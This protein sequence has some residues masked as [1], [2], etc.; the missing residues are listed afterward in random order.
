MI[1]IKQDDTDCRYKRHVKEC[2][3][4]HAQMMDSPG[5]NEFN[6]EGNGHAQM[7]ADQVKS[8]MLSEQVRR[9]IP[10][11]DFQSAIAKA[12]QKSLFVRKVWFQLSHYVVYTYHKCVILSC[13]FALSAAWHQR[14]PLA[15]FQLRHERQVY[16]MVIEVSKCIASWLKTCQIPY[17]SQRSSKIDIPNGFSKP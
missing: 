13:W 2:E 10:L 15:D 5:H 8:M 14:C 12:Q 4:V 3:R 11:R 9:F 1:L 7:S 6:L 16:A 17:Q